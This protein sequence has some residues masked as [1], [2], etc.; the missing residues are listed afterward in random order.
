MTE[1]R[2]DTGEVMFARVQAQGET[3]GLS[4]IK[5]CVQTL[6]PAKV[7]QDPIQRSETKPGEHMQDDGGTFH[8]EKEGKEHTRSG[9]A[10]IL[11][12]LACALSRV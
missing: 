11:G 7:G 5:A 4:T 2:L 8:D 3:G 1:D 10:A 12:S 6:R 9:F